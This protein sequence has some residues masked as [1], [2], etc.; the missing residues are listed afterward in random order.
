MDIEL[1][2]VHSST[3]PTAINYTHSHCHLQ[4]H[5]TIYAQLT[6]R[7]HSVL[8]IAVCI[9]TPPSIIESPPY[10]VPL[11]RYRPV[12]NPCPCIL[13]NLH[14]TSIY[15]PP[16]GPTIHP[17]IIMANVYSIIKAHVYSVPYRIT[18]YNVQPMNSIA[19]NIF[20][21]GMHFLNQYDF[22]KSIINS[23]VYLSYPVLFKYSFHWT[24]LLT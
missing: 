5:N 21:Y 19:F 3:L 6:T 11:S 22:T 10:D 23:T 18:R 12:W 4:S 13:S 7:R 2:Y 1:P 9:G 16:L 20:I 24:L 15:F 14:E 8:P 17:G